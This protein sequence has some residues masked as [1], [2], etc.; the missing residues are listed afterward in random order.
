MSTT[1]PNHTPIPTAT[2]IAMPA[3][4]ITSRATLDFYVR[5]FDATVVMVTPEAGDE[6]HHAELTID[7]AMFMCGTPR[8]DGLEQPP[9]GSAGY[10]ILDDP[11]KVDR[12]HAQALAAGGTDERP[13]Y[14]AGYG[15]R[16]CTVRDPD[17]NS[18][19]FGTYRPAGI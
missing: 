10:W 16:H 13:P 15:G 11:A 4:R 18:W 1:N 8:P 9:G 2:A 14:E 7:G 5:T 6:V 17:G 19:S 12:F 3:V